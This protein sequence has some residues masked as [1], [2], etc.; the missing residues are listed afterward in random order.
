MY[1]VQRGEAEVK[2]PYYKRHEKGRIICEGFFDGGNSVLEF[3]GKAKREAYMIKY[4]GSLEGCKECKLHE[5]LD[6]KW[7]VSN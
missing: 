5:M 6:E 2:C 3:H 4:C 1:E 7:G